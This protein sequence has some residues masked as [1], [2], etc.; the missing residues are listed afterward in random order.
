MFVLF[1]IPGRLS[2]ASQFGERPAAVQA[3]VVMKA[4]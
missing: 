4:R 2:E 3:K 1:A